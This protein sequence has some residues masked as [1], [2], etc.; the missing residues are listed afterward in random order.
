[1]RQGLGRAVAAFVLITAPVLALNERD[2]SAFNW[3]VADERFG[4]LSGF[5]WVDAED[6]RFVA[7]GDRGLFV[8]GRVVRDDA[9]QITG[10]EDTVL[11]PVRNPDGAQVD[12][13]DADSEGLAIR[14]DGRLF[15]TFEGHHRMWTYRDTGSE[16]AWMPRDPSFRSL[17]WNSGLE[18]LAIAPDNSLFTITEDTRTS[19]GDFPVYRYARGAWQNAGTLPRR[20]DYLI[21]GAD[22]GPD[23]YLYVLERGFSGIF[24]FRSRVRRFEWTGRALREIDTVMQSPASR[25]GNL[26]GLAVSRTA[27]GNLRLTMVADDNFLRLLRTEI[28]EYTLQESLD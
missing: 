10:I 5:D 19:Q 17:H 27:D 23:G 2:W 18:S 15:L 21:T 6:G 22:F 9:G 20:G 12:G 1:M 16:A 8:T 7:L 24:G 3:S 25:H 14:G 4:G 26:E 28:V 13:R 11:S